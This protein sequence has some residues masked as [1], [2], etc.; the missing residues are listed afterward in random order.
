MVSR[1]DLEVSQRE[2]AF[3][4]HVGAALSIPSANAAARPQPEAPVPAA[5][6]AAAADRAD[7]FEGLPFRG[8][9]ERLGEAILPALHAMREEQRAAARHATSGGAA[10]EA[11]VAPPAVPPLLPFTRW[12]ARS[13]AFRSTLIAE[14][15][16]K[17]KKA[18][19]SWDGLLADLKYY[20]P[21]S[22]GG[23]TSASA[24]PAPKARPRPFEARSA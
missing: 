8:L 11:P 1:H 3:T 24:P 12:A 15:P 7:P 5:E 18:R 6:P 22:S 16:G 21:F 2:D 14:E 19:L 17:R 10:D 9:A 23:S 13:E 4:L 20:S